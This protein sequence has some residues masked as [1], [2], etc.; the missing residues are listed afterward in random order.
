VTKPSDSKQIEERLTALTRDLILIPSIPSRPEDRQRCYEFIRNHLDGLPDIEIREFEHKGA[1]SLVAGAPDFKEPKILMCGHLDVITHPDISFYRSH[2][3][4]GRIYGP[5]AGDMKGALAVLLE[6]F[7]AIH[8]RNP[9]A[10][11]AIAVT[12]DEELGG[13]AGIGYLFGKENLRCKVAMIPD[14]GSIDEVT[15]E[16][17]GILHLQLTCEGQSGHAAR[18]WLGVNPIEIL[19]ERLAALQ[20]YF[21]GLE[22]KE[23]RWYPTCAVTVISTENQTTNRI[24][25]NASAIVDIRFPPPFTVNKLLTEIPAILGE[26]ITVGKI[27]AAEP[28]HLAPDELY[29]KITEEVTGKKVK[30]IQDD[31]G[32]DARFIAAHGIPVKMSRPIVGNLHAVDE[33]VDIGSLVQLY[34]IYEQYIEQKLKE[35]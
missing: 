14:G 18:P 4:D 15:V 21:K 26:K 1:P 22:R 9:S 24:P 32:S 13:E 6:V 23:D 27:I 29:R 12:S 2:I 11:L 31:G 10:S 34:H 33:W 7:R 16:E 8:T 19:M 5:G 28:T 20:K 30:L 17:K 35:K 3:K 25:S